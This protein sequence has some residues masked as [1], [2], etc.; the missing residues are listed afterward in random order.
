MCSRATYNYSNLTNLRSHVAPSTLK[1]CIFHG[2]SRPKSPK[3]VIDHDL[4][5]TTYATLSTDSNDLKVLQQIEWYR[6]VLDECSSSISISACYYNYANPSKQL[7]GFGIRLLT[8]SVLPKASEPRGSG[9]CQ[10]LRFKIA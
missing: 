9:A 1:I 4:V 3:G 8:S 10:A 5:L 6:V 7:T 2:S